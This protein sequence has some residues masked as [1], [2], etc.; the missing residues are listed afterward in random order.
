M[1]KSIP[2]LIAEKQQMYYNLL[3]EI[4][5]MIDNAIGL[6][7]KHNGREGV[8][9]VVYDDG[10]ADVSFINEE[11]YSEYMENVKMSELAHPFY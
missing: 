5:N 9:H 1:K 10:T 2:Q 6:D 3:K 11:D 4:S 7:V 8:I